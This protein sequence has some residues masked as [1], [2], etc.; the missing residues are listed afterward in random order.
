M[1]TLYFLKK[2]GIALADLGK[3]F[4]RTSSP[5]LLM[6]LLVKNEEAMLEENL[7]FHI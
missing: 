7:I 3:T 5:K 6:T 4:R 1:M 2:I